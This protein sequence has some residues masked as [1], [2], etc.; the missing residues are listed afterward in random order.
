MKILVA[1]DNA[2]T[3]TLMK[4]ILIRRGYEVVIARNGSAALR[5]LETDPGIQGVITDVMM[6]ESS[7]LELLR[8]L[9]ANELWRTLPTIVTTVRDDCETVA[10]A[11]RLGCR[12]Y[13]LKPIRPSRLL[14]S[15][16]KIFGR[17]HPVLMSAPEVMSRYA[18]DA[19]A[20]GKIS[21]D[22]AAQVDEA[23]LVLRDSSS[24][25]P[26]VN[27][28]RFSPIVESAT[29]LGAESLLA[30]IEGITARCGTP[31]LTAPQCA[32]ILDELLQVRQV[33]KDRTKPSLA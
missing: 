23:I 24:S 20:Y 33:L 8:A 13:I 27:R 6:P 22:F 12:G 2:V 29:L 14:E 26:S 1:E 21:G 15:V 30:E 25:L 31:Q 18:L 4:G 7:G 19:E 28:E 3:A 10:E 11:V 17:D 9:Q 5:A 32:R 16:A